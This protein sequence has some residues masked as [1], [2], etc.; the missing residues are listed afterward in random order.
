MI[1]DA[2]IAKKLAVLGH[3]VRLSIVRLLVRAGPASL[4]A[5][6]LGQQVNTAPNAMTFHLQKLVHADLVTS[7]RKGQFI[8]YS[9][10]FSDLQELAN[11]LVGATCCTETPDK[12]GPKCP[13]NNQHRIT[14]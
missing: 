12:C 5:G 4:C 6:H 9:A 3:P 13:T 11:H 7:H 14:P 8:I 10:A 2:I 1:T